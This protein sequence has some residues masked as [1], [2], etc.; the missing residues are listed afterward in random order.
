MTRRTLTIVAILTLTAATALPLQA[1]STGDSVAIKAPV[2]KPAPV[3]RSVAVLGYEVKWLDDLAEQKQT[4]EV[5]SLLV[6]DRLSAMDELVIVERAEIDK[7][8][9]EQQLNLTGLVDEKERVKIGKLLGARFLLWGRGVKVGEQIYISSKIIN[10]ETGQFKGIIVEVPVKTPASELFAK[11]CDELVRKLPATIQSLARDEAPE[12][13]P[14]DLLKRR[15]GQTRKSWLLAADEEHRRSQPVPVIDPA[16]RNEL[17][18]LLAGVDQKVTSLE[19]ADAKA[20][21]DGQKKMSSFDPESKADYHIVAEGF[22]E[23]G[24]RLRGDLVVCTARVEI[25]VTDARSGAVVAAGS[26]DSR[27]TDLSEQLAGKQ[28]L[29]KATRQLLLD[30]SPR[31]FTEPEQAAE[32]KAGRT[33]SDK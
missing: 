24:Q 15:V 32:V 25:K 5:L 9:A 13:S 2:A 30:L 29:R 23:F 22:S 27:A 11:V 10:V 14:I 1:Q 31:I 28:A 33:S 3:L 20:V 4:G 17:E 12:A 16:I 6:S 19:K 8:M 18:H 26:I 7:L 21:I